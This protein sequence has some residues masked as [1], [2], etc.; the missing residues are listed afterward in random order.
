MHH[1][2]FILIQLFGV[3]WEV[4]LFCVG[5]GSEAVS[6]GTDAIHSSLS[7]L[8][9]FRLFPHLVQ[10]LL[11]FSHVDALWIN[12]N[13]LVS[14][15]KKK[16]KWFS[17]IHLRGS[18]PKSSD[19]EDCR[20]PLGPQQVTAFDILAIRPW[21]WPAHSTSPCR[22]RCRRCRS[23][24]WALRRPADFHIILGSVVWS[25]PHPNVRLQ[26]VDLV[27]QRL[28]SQPFDGHF[29]E[30]SEINWVGELIVILSLPWSRKFFLPPYLSVSSWMIDLSSDMP[31][32]EIFSSWKLINYPP[33]FFPFKSRTILNERRQFLAA[34]SLWIHCFFS[35]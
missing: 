5:S 9:L 15:K 28:G 7:V 13:Y 12:R 33:L 4:R 19:G 11:A 25:H 16:K 6:A 31:K 23:P 8:C 26:A 24:R 1:C 2:L 34:M 35:R 14:L 20:F 32:S 17:S 29:A 3:V 27:R 22:A 10:F 30:N 21:P 18:W